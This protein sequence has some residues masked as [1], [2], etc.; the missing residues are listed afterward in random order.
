MRVSDITRQDVIDTLLPIQHMNKTP[1]YVR[2]YIRAIMD[3]AILYGWRTDNP[4]D[5]A[6]A[7]M[8]SNGKQASV[9]HYAR[10]AVRGDRRSIG[11]GG[12]VPSAGCTWACRCAS[13]R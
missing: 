7:A 3:W 2:K 6:V 13:L 12:A 9:K 1:A 11:Q 8:L 5:A 10:A 4:S